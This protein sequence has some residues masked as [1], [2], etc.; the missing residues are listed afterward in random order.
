M[1]TNHSVKCYPCNG[2][3]KL[4]TVDGWNFTGDFITDK[5]GNTVPLV[6]GAKT[7]TVVCNC[8]GGLGYV[9]E[10]APLRSQNLTERSNAGAQDTGIK[11]EEG[12]PGRN[13]FNEGSSR[14]AG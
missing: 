11:R 5:D 1:P 13:N 8:C 3:G 2:K 9:Q 6:L 12:F 10:A 14:G 4:W 7:R